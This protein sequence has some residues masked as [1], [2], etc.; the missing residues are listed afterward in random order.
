MRRKIFGRVSSNIDK[1]QRLQKGIRDVS[2]ED[3]RR[4]VW[5]SIVRRKRE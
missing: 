2:I 1:A 3:V 5:M 4:L